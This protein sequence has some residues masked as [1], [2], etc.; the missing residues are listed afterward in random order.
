MSHRVFAL[1][2]CGTVSC[3]AWAALQAQTPAPKKILI[4]HRGASAYAPEHSADAYRLA[5]AQGADFVEQD[6]AVTKDGV[7]VSIHD[8]T[9]ERTTNV[10]EV[11][12]DRFA[13]D[14]S[15]STP[16]RRWYV[17]DFTLAEIKRLD[18]GS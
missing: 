17:N 16:V 3:L 7:L 9:L 5:I 1:A 4:A 10:E 14:K 2:L 8:L 6:L 13:E 11:F 12:P 15:G 18:A